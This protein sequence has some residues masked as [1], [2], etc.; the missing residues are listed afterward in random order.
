MSFLVQFFGKKYKLFIHTSYTH[1]YINIHVWR[2]R[3]WA[4]LT[5]MGKTQNWF[6][7]G[8]SSRKHPKLVYKVLLPH[9]K[10]VPCPQSAPVPSLT[11]C[12]GC[13]S[14]LIVGAPL[15]VVAVN[16]TGQLYDCAPATGICQPVVLPREW[17][18]QEWTLPA[19]LM[20]SFQWIPAKTKPLNEFVWLSVTTCVCLLS[21][22]RGCE[23]VPGP[24]SGGCYQSL[25]VAGEFSGSQEG[26]ER[27]I[28]DWRRLG[29]DRDGSW[30]E[31]V[32]LGS[33]AHRGALCLQACGPTVQR[34]CE[35]NMYAKGSCLL[36]GS[37]LQ[38]I[39]AVP[40]TLPGGFAGDKVSGEHSL[41]Y[42]VR[43]WSLL[44]PSP[45]GGQYVAEQE[46]W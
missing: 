34:A 21:S 38:F 4:S 39:Q 27:H 15:E 46:L 25:P 44:L 29:G 43:E 3:Q 22:P 33:N 7:N 31:R 8:L 37:S 41:H 1:F 42:V 2:V 11:V 16:Q 30:G 40:A 10:V 20:C 17:L 26:H 12:F 24:V 5:C 6:L 28:R 45:S 36:L 18:S 35:K 9:G 13:S 19:L 14:R 23:H 32:R